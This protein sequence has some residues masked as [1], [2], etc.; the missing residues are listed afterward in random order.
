ML[1]CNVINVTYSSNGHITNVFLQKVSVCGGTDPVGA[2]C[3]VKG[4]NTTFSG[5]STN[6][7]L[8]VA[9][10]T[11]GLLCLNANQTTNTTCDDYQIQF[12]CD[13]R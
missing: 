5:D 4:A 8:Q 12:T 3:R 13:G 6:Q 10:S 1:V 7:V 11:A 2:T 9:C